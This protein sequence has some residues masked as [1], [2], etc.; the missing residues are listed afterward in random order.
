MQRTTERLKTLAQQ[1]QSA[2]GLACLLLLPSCLSVYFEAAADG[3]RQKC[4]EFDQQRQKLNCQAAER[5]RARELQGLRSV[6]AALAFRA[7]TPGPS[8]DQGG[9]LC[10]DA[11]V[12]KSTLSPLPLCSE[13]YRHST[14]SK[15][16][17]LDARRQGAFLML[18]V[19][20]VNRPF[21]GHQ[22]SREGAKDLR[23][24]SVRP[25]GASS[26]DPSSS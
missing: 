12:A 18:H 13:C 6:A 19:R 14:H 9:Q 20:A 16:N 8:G 7:S 21:Y 25:R 10:G 11:W 4:H 2:S 17:T 3:F 1:F 24:E 23:K 15:G 5:K 22:L 26:S